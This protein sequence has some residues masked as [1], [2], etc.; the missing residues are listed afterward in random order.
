MKSMARHLLPFALPLALMPVLAL[1]TL[2]LSVTR[3]LAGECTYGDDHY[4]SAIEQVSRDQS[5]ENVGAASEAFYCLRCRAED[6]S[7]WAGPIASIQFASCRKSPIRDRLASACLPLLSD[8]TTLPNFR[9]VPRFACALLLGS[10]G[11]P[12]VGESDIFRIITK[13][14]P[15]RRPL[16]TD[17]FMS[18]A[19]LRDPRTLRFLTNEYEV[20]SKFPSPRRERRIED[21]INCLYHIPGDSALALVRT[22]KGKETDPQIQER[23]LRVLGR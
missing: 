16:A 7:K 20:D 15:T 4:L 2:T 11:I 22:I 21:I 13:E 9:V 12:K 14:I 1:S 5:V 8:T 10:Y 18:L 17:D 6:A 23:C 3:S 19:V